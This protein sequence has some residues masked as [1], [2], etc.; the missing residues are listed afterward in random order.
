MPLPP[1]TARAL[2]DLGV[3][4]DEDAPL[5][6]RT[7]WRAGGPAGGLVTARDLPALAAIQRAAHDTGCSVFVL[8]NASNLLVSDRG[9]PGLVL[10]LA[11]ELASISAEGD[12]PVLRL[13]A[14]LKLMPFIGRMQREGWTGLEMLAGVPGTMGG[15]VV[16][17]AGT[18]L[19]E[20]VDALLDVEVVLPDGT[21]ETLTRDDLRMSYRT[22]HLPDGAIVA[23]ARLRT[24]GD[25]PE[26]SRRTIQAHLDYR[27]NT[28][29]VDVPTCG[30]TFRN[31]PG[32]RAGRLIE[33]AGL[34]GARIGG[35]QV[36]EK[37]ANFLVNTGEATA[38][39]IRRLIEHVQAEVARVH[40]VELVREVHYAG[41]W[42]GW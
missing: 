12:P 2:H 38:S 16:M 21:I 4:F 14:G 32:D 42:S 17:N 29:P 25:D 36:S 33:A 19:G 11:G 1:D 22:A 13:G 39:D 6:K 30:S 41:D 18:S 7:W 37:H 23:S 28:Q 24:T 26:A 35:A 5:V 10:R 31:P 40:G 8:G 3:A 9:I 27:A 34:K 20:V 15:A